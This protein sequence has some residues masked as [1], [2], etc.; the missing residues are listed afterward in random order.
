MHNARDFGR[1][2]IQ[3]MHDRIV[4][5]VKQDMPPTPHVSPN[6]SRN[7]HREQFLVGNGLLC[8]E[9]RPQT[10]EPEASQ[11]GPVAQGTSCIRGKF[12]IRF[13]R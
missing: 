4:V 1:S 8:L 9:R 11:K 7:D 5:R 6:V 3:N 12:N 10:R 2:R 13:R